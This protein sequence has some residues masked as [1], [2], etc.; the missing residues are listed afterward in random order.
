MAETKENKRQQQLQ[1]Y[2]EKLEQGIRDVFSSEAYADYLRTLATFHNYS[3]RNTILIHQQMKDIDPSVRPS[4]LAG[5]NKW[6]AQYERNVKKGA[7]SI[8]IFAPITYKTKE[9]QPK[10]DPDT[11]LPLRDE[12]G[13]I[14][15]EEAG[16]KK[17]AFK[18]VPVFDVSQTEGK[19]LQHFIEN[20]EGDVQYYDLFRQA[21]EKS[22]DCA[23]KY[24]LID[25]GT[26]GFFRRRDKSIYISKELNEAQ[27]VATLIH[28][29]THAELHKD[30]A[31]ENETVAER[32]ARRNREEVE[33]ESVAFVVSQYF[34]IE[35]G[36]NSF[37]YVADWSSDKELS[38]L[39][40]SLE[41]IKKTA[42]KMIETIDQ[43][44]N[45]LKQEHGIETTVVEAEAVRIM[46]SQEAAVT[47]ASD[48]YDY[49]AAYN[50]AHNLPPFGMDDPTVVI[51]QVA[52][53]IIDGTG[54][55]DI[56]ETVQ[57]RMAEPDEL[58]A[59]GKVGD[60]LLRRLHGFEKIEYIM[61]DPEQAAPE[62]STLEQFGVD[63]YTFM[64]DRRA[65]AGNPPYVE[66]ELSDKLDEFS[67]SFREG[68]NGQIRFVL[69]EWA[70]D[71]EHG[72]QAQALLDRL[73]AV[74]NELW[75]EPVQA[76][77]RDR[78]EQFG[79]D[80][81]QV[82]KS[83]YEKYPLQYETD[84]LTNSSPAYI[85]H[86]IEIGYTTQLEFCFGQLAEQPEFSRHADTFRARLAELEPLQASEFDLGFGH[87][88]N[89]LIVWN[90]LEEIDGDYVK[91]AHISQDRTI[92]YYHTSLPEEVKAQIEKAARASELTVSATQDTPVF[93]T[94]AEPEPAPEE[95]Q[96]DISEALPLPIPDI[97]VTPEQRSEFRSDATRS[98][99]PLN[100][101]SA[102]ELYH[103]DQTI[104]MVD[105]Q[106]EPLLVLDEQEIIQSNGMFGIDRDEWLESVA[107]EQMTAELANTEASMEAHLLYGRG[108]KYG[109]YQIEDFADTK[110]AFRS[111]EEAGNMLD[112]KDYTLKYMG[113]LPPGMTLDDLYAKHNMD[114]RPAGQSMRSMSMSDIVVLKQDGNITAHY[115][116][117]RS[118]EKV[119]QFLEQMQ[120]ENAEILA[121]ALDTFAEDYDPYG[122]RDNVDD[123]EE[124]LAENVRTIENGGAELDGIFDYLRGVVEDEAS[125]EYAQEA[126][127]LIYR[128][129]EYRKRVGMQRVIPES[130][131]AAAEMSGEDNYNMI[132]GIP[133][134]TSPKP[135][136]EEL[137]ADVAAG[138]PISLMDLA[139]AVHDD[140]KPASVLGQLAQNQREIAEQD[141]Q[142]DDA[143]QKHD[144]NEREH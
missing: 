127:T 6:P 95:K 41:T 42:N 35:T 117:E 103:Q 141:A 112:Y 37:G 120:P 85:I 75:P 77:M 88:G 31:P 47:F 22:T 71:T 50:E 56:R 4:L 28:E 86:Q 17:L 65:E 40:S 123:P 129:T 8:R 55:E 32:E 74:E 29:M 94:P 18:I 135:T 105:S 113:E 126:Q 12:N 122:Y 23:V 64:N 83:Y 63:Y 121:A 131:I 111:L 36:A 60:T 57:H 96:S 78:R 13:K 14:I 104:Y 44:F 136:P 138:K 128:M 33:A 115:C 21:L 106:G 134:N 52:K 114:D 51:A 130:H 19:P 7:K 140:K 87:L 24:V 61:P 102:L 67:T 133:N 97:S 70:S 119:P 90:R 54:I 15:M 73:D 98:L 16:E 48:Y 91:L 125:A 49:M 116:D 62:L 38:D 107:F 132:D 124:A 89:G 27:T 142:R 3:Y 79:I 43:K 30:K 92:E 99:M 118:F 68:E 100:R 58:D 80:L 93:S 144:K 139:A 84:M 69:E 26:D 143:D 66:G 109:I 5:Y 82:M 81:G 137:E 34:G 2:T 72:E 59:D 10:L 11:G 45:E 101:D 1:E 76:S 110:Y 46:P 9:E 20:I 25:D 39:K 53:E 108:D